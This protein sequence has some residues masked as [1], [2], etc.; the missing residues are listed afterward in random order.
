MPAR[1]VPIWFLAVKQTGGYQAL[2]SWK[3]LSAISE[4]I[5]YRSGVRVPLVLLL[6]EQHQRRLP[7]LR[8]A[9]GPAEATW[10]THKTDYYTCGVCA[11]DPDIWPFDLNKRGSG[12]RPLTSDRGGSTV[13]RS[14]FSR[15][16]ALG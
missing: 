1:T 6:V 5:R 10:R 12:N 7:A 9:R 16:Q 3:R 13:G 14:A 15:P 8:V 11:A 2:M 4:M